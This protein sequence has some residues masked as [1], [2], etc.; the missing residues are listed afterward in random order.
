[1]TKRCTGCK[2][3]LPV[4][5]FATNRA[6]ADGYNGMCR[7]CK[8]TY[9]AAY[10]QRTKEV[11][12]EAR[13]VRREVDRILIRQALWG[14]LLI[15][16]CVD[17]GEADPVV[18]DFDHVRGVKQDN[19][20]QMVISLTSWARILEEIGKCE[21]RCANCHRRRTAITQGWGKAF[22]GQQASVAEMALAPDS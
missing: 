7:T 19:I 16:P 21:V 22:L 1:M 5:E 2:L 12:R 18:L 4:E 11:H 8:K 13:A 6:Q 10:Y 15:H 3:V 20:S 17:C 14:Y 9:N